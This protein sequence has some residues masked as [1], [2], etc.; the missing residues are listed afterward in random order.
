MSSSPTRGRADYTLVR[1]ILHRKTGK[2]EDTGRHKDTKTGRHRKTQEDTKTGRQLDRK[3]VRHKDRNTRK[4][5]KTGNQ[6][7][8]RAERGRNRQDISFWRG[9][10]DPNFNQTPE[11]NPNP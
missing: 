4:D 2:Q 1:Y 10:K 8:W 11:P 6:V 3:T 9:Y 7:T 5:R